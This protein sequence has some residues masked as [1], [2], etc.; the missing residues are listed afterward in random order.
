MFLVTFTIKFLFQGYIICFNSVDKIQNLLLKTFSAYHFLTFINL[1]FDLLPKH[2]IFDHIIALIRPQSQPII[3]FIKL[4]PIWLCQEQNLL[5]KRE[6]KHLQVHVRYRY[7]I[8]VTQQVL[9]ICFLETFRGHK[10]LFNNIDHHSQKI[11]FLKWAQRLLLMREPR[12]DILALLPDLL[13]GALMG[14]SNYELK[15]KLLDRVRWG[16]WSS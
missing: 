13:L 9:K 2:L 4:P 15:T 10:I 6:F 5:K 7:V 16:L 12:N 8:Q 1:L 3:D 14:V 11:S